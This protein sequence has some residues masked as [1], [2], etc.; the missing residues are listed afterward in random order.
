MASDTMNVVFNA[1]SQAFDWM[2]S[3]YNSTGFLK[4]VIAALSLAIAAG[5]LLASLSVPVGSDEASGADGGGKK[6]N[7][8]AGDGD[9]R[10]VG[11]F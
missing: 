6:N 1:I 9:Y 11:R 10:G 3:I 5:Y 7:H 8:G 4:T 2:M